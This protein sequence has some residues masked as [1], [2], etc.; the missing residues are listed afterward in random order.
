M[1]PFRLRPYVKKAIWGEERWVLSGMPG[2]ESV[3]E[4]GRTLS[5]LLA[6]MKG[7]LVGESIFRKRPG[8]FPLLA[9]FI[10]AKKDLSLQVHPDD[11]LA[12]ARHGS[13][14]KTEMWYVVSAAPGAKIAAGFARPLSPEEYARLSSGDATGLLSAVVRHDSGPGETFFLPAG[15]VHAIGG[16]NLIAEI[17][18][19]SDVTYRLCD[20]GRL[21]ADGRPRELHVGLAKDAVDLSAGCEPVRYDRSAGRAELVSCGH[22][23]VERMAVDGEASVDFGA[24]SF[25]AVLCAEGSATVNGT[26]VEAG[27]ALLVPAADR[28]LRVRGEATLLA[29]YINS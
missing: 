7:D 8:G 27:G 10:D 6:D 24:D 2:R 17:Q 19:P 3:A 22:F 28:A 15:T 21:D 16:G 4:D 5:E 11:G 14:G 13:P 29:A 23:T 1:K 25:V 18:Q 12:M 26:D 9:K 20:Y